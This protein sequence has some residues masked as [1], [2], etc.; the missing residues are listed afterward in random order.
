MSD[1]R[2]RAVSSAG[3]ERRRLSFYAR[4]PTPAVLAAQII[5]VFLCRISSKIETAGS[6]KSSRLSPLPA[7]L[8]QNA[9]VVRNDKKLLYSHCIQIHIVFE[10]KKDGE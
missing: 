4:P 6:L 9:K 1:E 8:V 3:V 5:L 2:R 7:I 10:Y